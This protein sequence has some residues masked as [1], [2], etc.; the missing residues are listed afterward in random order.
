MKRLLDKESHYFL[1]GLGFSL[2]NTN[3]DS[4][5]CRYCLSDNRWFEFEEKDEIHCLSDL[6]GEVFKQGMDYE[7]DR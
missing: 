2:G 7:R 6:L 4:F 5:K 1:L 3:P